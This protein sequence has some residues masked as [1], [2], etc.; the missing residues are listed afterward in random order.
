[1]RQH[2]WT[3][4]LGIAAITI[5]LVL[6]ACSGGPPKVIYPD[7]SSTVPANNP[8][9]IEA[10]KSAREHSR[11]MLA[12]NDLLRAQV[13]T[14]QKQ[15]EDLRV[16]IGSV[17]AASAPRPATA[18]PTPPEVAPQGDPL[19]RLGR[20][21]PAGPDA[22]Q[23]PSPRSALDGVPLPHKVATFGGDGRRAQLYTRTFATNETRFT[24]DAAAIEELVQLALQAANIEI[25]G[26][27]D[28][29]VA[30]APN[31][32]VAYGRAYHARQ[33]LVN[34]GVDAAKIRT[35]V[36]PAGHFVV[37]NDTPQG[38]AQNR[39]VHILFFEKTPDHGQGV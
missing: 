29:Y 5:T 34:A 18:T 38:R 8:A 23:K 15:L 36:F 19:E 27:T 20:Q 1:M 21:A 30:D 39:R 25:Q 4:G 6:A 37:P 26:A 9:R 32:R 3:A 16:A 17:L 33:L 10:L 13:A 2:Q 22:W 28:S 31:Q 11:A 14:M 7:G 35:R 12:E 24:L